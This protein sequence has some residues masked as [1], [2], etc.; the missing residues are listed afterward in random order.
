MATI[1]P[2]EGRSVHQIQS[3]QVIVDLNSVAKELVENA[4][5]AGATAI[6]VRFKNNGLDSIEVQDNGSGI[7]PEDFQTIGTLLGSPKNPRHIR[8][9][10]AHIYSQ[11]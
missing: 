10:D 2:I 3:G 5:D 8:R 4:L 7:A 1:K 6:E 11:L 9:C